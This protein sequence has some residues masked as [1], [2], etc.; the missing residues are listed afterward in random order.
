[1]YVCWGLTLCGRNTKFSIHIMPGYLKFGCNTWISCWQ[2]SL[3]L[4]QSLPVVSLWE[5]AAF[6]PFFFP[7]NG[8]FSFSCFSPFLLPSSPACLSISPWQWEWNS[9]SCRSSWHFSGWKFS[10]DSFYSAGTCPWPVLIMS[11]LFLLISLMEGQLPLELLLHCLK[12]Q[13]R[14]K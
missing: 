10:S 9:L 6:I 8:N 3:S 7:H 5:K 2:N 14:R 12:S 4:D 1:M 13:S 11:F